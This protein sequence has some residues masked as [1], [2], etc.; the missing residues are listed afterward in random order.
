LGAGAF[1]P[2]AVDRTI[3]DLS[4]GHYE[5]VAGSGKQKIGSP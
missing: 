2:F 3:R 4:D 1:S 5:A